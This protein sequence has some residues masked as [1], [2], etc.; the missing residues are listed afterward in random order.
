MDS[1]LEIPSG[2][3]E[4][5]LKK[6]KKTCFQMRLQLGKHISV[7]GSGNGAQG[8]YQRSASHEIAGGIAELAD[9]DRSVRRLLVEKKNY[10]KIQS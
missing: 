7:E 3:F 2:H 9:K 6:K 10:F 4:T 1:A 8:L 5:E